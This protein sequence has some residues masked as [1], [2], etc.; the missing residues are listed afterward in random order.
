MRRLGCIA[1]LAAPLALARHDDARA[2]APITPVDHVDL[3]GYM[4]RWYVIASIPTRFERG[5]HNPVETYELAPDGSVCTGFRF[6]PDGF[7]AAPKT[8]H[9]PA[10]IVRG[11]G[12]AEWRVHLFGFLRAQYLVGWLAPDASQV[13]VV[14]DARDHLWYMAREPV[15]AEVDYAAMLA[16]ARAL[17]YEVAK[18]EKMPQRWPEDAQDGAAAPA[19]G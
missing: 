4:G 18:I 5:G 11:S 6:R 15:V 13:L 8:I 19:C 12:N 3:A 9:S 17:G 16:R 2:R 14:R 10:T 7:D 1:L